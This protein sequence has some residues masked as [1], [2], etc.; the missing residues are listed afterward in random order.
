VERNLAA[1]VA[2]SDTDPKVQVVLHYLRE[3]R[4]LETNG[5]IIF[6]QYRTTAE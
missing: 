2:G 1:V 6:S 5:A 3:R 4:W